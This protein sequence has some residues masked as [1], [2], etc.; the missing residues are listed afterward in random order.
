MSRVGADVQKTLPFSFSI[1]R[2]ARRRTTSIEVREGRVSV[3]APL[4]VSEQL[5]TAFVMEKEAWIR[6]KISEQQQRLA[7]VPVREYV[8]GASLPYLDQ[9]LVLETATGD[10]ARV[11]CREAAEPPVLGVITSRRSR[12]PA[13]QQVRRLVVGWYQQQALALLTRRTRL[14]AERMGLRVGEI[15]VKATR[16]RWGQCTIRGDIQYNWQIILAPAR[17]VDYLVAHE[18]CHLR[19]HNHSP[20]FWALVEEVCPEWRLSRQWLRANG[21]QLVL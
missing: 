16:S 12:L 10:L 18:V 2:S 21:T 17:I 20:A 8:D 4:G 5:L 11:Y 6:R 19:H 15:T 7:A 13:E 9:Q 1:V 14:L 3:R